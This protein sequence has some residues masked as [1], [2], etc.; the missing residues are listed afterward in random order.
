MCELVQHLSFFDYI[1]VSG[2]LENR[3]N[4]RWLVE[5]FPLLGKIA[6]QP[7]GMKPLCMNSL[8]S[9]N[10]RI[11]R[12]LARAYEVSRCNQE[13]LLPGAHG[14][15]TTMAIVRMHC[16]DRYHG[17]LVNV[18][19]LFFSFFVFRALVTAMRWNQRH[20]KTTSIRT[21]QFGRNSLQRENSRNCSQ[22]QNSTN[23]SP[24]DN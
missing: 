13:W 1:A 19:S 24:I 12:S 23:N 2:S 6:L 16:C 10:D 3:W 18:W 5:P 9:Q 4:H 20:W 11:R 14:K 17:A 22:T 8:S 15:C 21:V 7:L